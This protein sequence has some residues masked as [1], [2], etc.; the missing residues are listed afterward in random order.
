MQRVSGK[1]L[2]A[3]TQERLFKP[4]GMTNTQWRDDFTEVVRNRATAYDGSAATGFHTDM[5][6][7]NMIGN[8]GLLSTMRDLILWN[9]NL[10]NP[11]VGGRAFTEA[12]ETRMR[13]TNGRT[14]TYAL[15]LTVDDYRGVREVS[16]G[17]STAG[18]RTHLSRF[19]EQHVSVAVWCNGST[20]GPAALL[21]QVA[22][23]VLTFPQATAAQASSERAEVAPASIA[24]WAGLYRDRFTDQTLLL[25]ATERGLSAPGGRGGVAWYARGGATFLSPQGEATFSGAIGSRNFVLVRSGADTAR[26]EEVRPARSVRAADYVGT[27]GSDELD[28]KLTIVSRDGK[29]F[30]RRRPADEIELRGVYAD[31]FQ[32]PGLGS[33]RFARDARGAVT[34][35]GIFAGRV[36]DVRFRRAR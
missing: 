32:A 30:L 33:L 3:F 31:D 34:G 18:Y 23:L 21:H 17:G 15:G 7:T 29:L 11:K 8:G 16:H 9:E 22:D 25:T 1:T 27:Y 6:F 10:D 5:P 19:P 35:F 24:R 2:D 12:L 36:L 4:L 26:F 13:L 14:I 20:T 28:V